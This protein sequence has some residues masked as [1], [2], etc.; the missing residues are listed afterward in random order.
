MAISNDSSHVTSDVETVRAI[1]TAMANIQDAAKATQAEHQMGFV[2]SLKI[3]R[4][5]VA[6]SI[7]L[8]TAIVM[9]GFDLILIGNL[10]GFPAFKEKFG[11]VQPNGSYELSAT[12]QTALSMGSLIGQIIG[13]F[14]NGYIADRFGYRITMMGGLTLIV[15]FIFIPFFSQSVVMFLCGQILLGIP[16]GCFQTLACTYA[17]EVVPTQLRAYLTTYVNLCWVFGQIIASG[18]LRG[19]VNRTDSWGYRIPVSIQW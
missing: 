5:G 14:L 3:Y 4:K 19:L 7:M 9:E 6:W 2:Q 18:V 11:S 15:A 12:W 1:D 8:S 16:F 13:L 10:L 17:S